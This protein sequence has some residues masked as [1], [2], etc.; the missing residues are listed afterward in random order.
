MF[1]VHMPEIALV[2]FL[3][4][5]HDP[6]GRD[7]IG[8]RTLAFSSLMPGGWAPQG[9]RDGPP[10]EEEVAGPGQQ[11]GFLEQGG[12]PGCPQERRGGS[13]QTP[14]LAPA[15]PGYRHVY[16][17]GMEE[18]SIFV[19]VAVSD[20]SGKVSVMWGPW[21]GSA[22]RRG[23]VLLGGRSVA[24]T[25]PFRHPRLDSGPSA[26]ALRCPC[27]GAGCLLPSGV[28]PALGVGGGGCVVHSSGSWVLPRYPH[29]PR[30]STWARAGL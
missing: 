22:P 11:E 17:E 29:W 20:I 25:S 14:S 28:C 4:W 9:P 30:P 19:H 24:S 12:R 1:T 27:L 15:P 8:Q 7:F 10:P 5:D 3:V 6:I 18:A 16:L 23:A 21:V 2:R 26:P 13:L